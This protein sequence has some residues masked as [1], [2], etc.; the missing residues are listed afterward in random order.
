MSCV[1]YYNKRIADQKIEMQYFSITQLRVDKLLSSLDGLLPETVAFQLGLGHWTTSESEHRDTTAVPHAK[2]NRKYNPK[3][4]KQRF[5][6][7]TQSLIFG[8]ESPLVARVH[9]LH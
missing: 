6:S 5:I 7:Y 2:Q 9:G 3:T 8:R 1:F 4:Q